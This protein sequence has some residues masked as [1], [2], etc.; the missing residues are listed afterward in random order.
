M[1]VSRS[2]SSNPLLTTPENEKDQEKSSAISEQNGDRKDTGTEQK[3]TSTPGE[4]TRKKLATLSPPRK[5]DKPFMR[6]KLSKRE[7]SVSS[8]LIIRPVANP[9]DANPQSAKTPDGK[10]LAENRKSKEVDAATVRTSSDASSPSKAHDDTR[11]P[12]S[13][14][15]LRTK[16]PN[17][18]RKSLSPEQQLTSDLA[19]LLDKQ[20]LRKSGRADDEI[21][22]NQMATSLQRFSGKS[23]DAKV[24]VDELML[25]MFSEEMKTSDAWEIA[26]QI[27]VKIK[28]AYFFGRDETSVVEE[29]KDKE[30]ADMLQFL[31]ASF[32]G[33]FF[34]VSG[35][36]KN[37]L[38]DKL[39][40][41]IQAVDH[42]QIRAL[43]SSDAGIRM[44][45]EKFMQARKAWLA[46]TLLDAF[47]IPL[48][49]REFF[50][51]R[52]TMESDKTAAHIIQAL[53]AALSVSATDLL[54]ESLKS[55]PE[56]IA[57]LLMQRLKHQSRLGSGQHDI[58]FPGGPSS[59]AKTVSPKGQR[60]EQLKTLLDKTIR[61]LAPH[62]LSDDML[63]LIRSVNRE[64]VE[65]DERLDDDVLLREWLD[66]ARKVDAKAAVVKE[67]Q[68]W[69]T[70]REEQI[71]LDRE[72]VVIDLVAKLAQI[73]STGG[74]LR[75]APAPRLSGDLTLAEKT[76]V[77]SPANSPSSSTSTTQR[78]VAR[79]PASPS[80]R[81]TQHK[82]SKTAD[83]SVP[84]E[85]GL[86]AELTPKQRA[87]LIRIYPDLL[88]DCVKDAAMI[89]AAE[90]KK[91]RPNPA[92]GIWETGRN[93][94]SIAAESLPVALRVKLFPSSRLA[95]E[96]RTI[97][98]AELWKLL[99][100]DALKASPLG[101]RI[102]A[103]R[104]EAL[105]LAG[106]SLSVFQLNLEKDHIEEKKNLNQ[107]F[108]PKTD[109]LVARIFGQ[110][111][112]EAGIPAEIIDSCKVFDRK[113][114]LWIA[115]ELLV[116]KPSITPEEIDGLRSNL[117]FDLLITRLL[118]PMVMPANNV[119][120]SVNETN[121][122]SAFRRS[123]K[124]MWDEK[125][126]ND[127]KT[128]QAPE[129]MSGASTV[130]VVST[131]QTPVAQSSSS[132]DS[133]EKS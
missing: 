76:P 49:L 23:P 29:K 70:E 46:K 120:D 125:L 4:R 9:D 78:R 93:K 42:R 131:R 127:F 14:P 71:T 83:V 54:A 22:V 10:F 59:L 98:H 126:F 1:S 27:A 117:V 11:L 67:F 82:R 48:V 118:Y 37:R 40:L 87:E 36:E 122:S 44:S 128:L 86:S 5:L 102:A 50:P 8:P 31:V 30:S 60:R 17:S 123:V 3:K 81:Q 73:E 110:G 108:K 45:H 34:N 61:R 24:R 51:A 53:H 101:T 68:A 6:G 107:K 130:S 79:S 104:A 103:D 124:A 39:R 55:P 41:F 72:F 90:G 21:A 111:L 85:K 18:A 115:E 105:Q 63:K 100:L 66:L 57:Q 84:V 121:Y 47:L 80:N 114:M 16:K 13:T 116:Q 62:T 113:L 64:W 52:G 15:K 112:A 133:T 119:E 132:T 74:P 20:L 75:M 19:E 77:T 25:K 38:P 56:D 12:S 106:K 69:M 2:T 97:S 28:T 26:R 129:A 92:K 94:F 99:T 109:A 58:S 33:A 32:A 7:R 96:N 88:L 91:W 35:D 65:S 89:K 43:L 95:N